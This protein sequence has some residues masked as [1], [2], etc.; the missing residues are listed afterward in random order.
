MSYFF[1]VSTKLPLHPLDICKFKSLWLLPA[2]F[3]AEFNN[4]MKVWHFAVKREK[5]NG[6]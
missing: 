3:S 4:K 2:C 5:G 1:V 6:V